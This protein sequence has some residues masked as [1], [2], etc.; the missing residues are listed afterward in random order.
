MEATNDYALFQTVEEQGHLLYHHYD[1]LALL[2]ATMKEF[3]LV[4]HRL[5]TTSEV[6]HTSDRGLPTN[7]RHS[8][9]VPRPTQLSTQVSDAPVSFLEKY[10]GT[11][12]KC[13]SFLLQCSLYFTY[14]R[15]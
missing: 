6:L 9:P 11:P 7:G 13:G 4:L 1:Q 12:S 5:D 8:E 3:L 15:W 10:D 14:Q 2:G